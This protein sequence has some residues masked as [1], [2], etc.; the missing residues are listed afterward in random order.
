MAVLASTEEALVAFVE[1]MRAEDLPDVAIQTFEHYYGQLREGQTGLIPESALQPIE[2]LPDA[3]AFG[4]DLADAGRAALPQTVL[5]KLN[6]GLGTGMG[7]E[8]A[9]SLLIVKDDLS[10]LDIIA[11]QA[12][13][14]SVPLVLMNSFSTREDSLSRVAQLSGFVDGYPARLRAAP[15]SEDLAGRPAPGEVAGQPGT[16]VVS[17]GTWRHLC[18]SADQ[19]YPG[20]LAGGRLPLRVCLQRR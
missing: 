7:L 1:R 13:Q 18:G 4:A 11:R 3:E 9:K 10:F 19:R 5:L 20:Y 15:L 2:T 14:S 8:K 17:T 6:G 12:L 16:G